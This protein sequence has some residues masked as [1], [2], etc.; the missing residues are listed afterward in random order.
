MSKYA[1]FWVA[2]V[3][4]A[5][6]AALQ[7]AQP[8]LGDGIVSAQEWLTIAL[9]FVGAFAVYAVPNQQ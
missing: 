9:A 7:A 8:A 5:I 1:K 3:V 4:A 6:I 2:L